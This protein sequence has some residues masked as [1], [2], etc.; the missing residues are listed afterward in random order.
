MKLGSMPE[1]LS[2]A[3]AW[4]KS[5]LITRSQNLNSS[6]MLATLQSSLCH[7]V[8]PMNRG[9]LF[10]MMFPTVVIQL[11]SIPLIYSLNYLSEY[12]TL[13]CVHLC[14]CTRPI[15]IQFN[16]LFILYNLIHKYEYSCSAIS[17]SYS[18]FAISNSYSYFIKS[19]SI[20]T[21]RIQHLSRWLIGYIAGGQYY[22]QFP[23]FFVYENCGRS[24]VNLFER[25]IHPLLNYRTVSYPLQR[26]LLLLANHKVPKCHRELFY[27]I[28]R[29]M[30][31]LN[32]IETIETTTVSLS[33]DCWPRYHFLY[34]MV[35]IT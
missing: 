4:M 5:S 26:I 21:S 16:F 12:V 35:L 34:S 24:I 17:H 15:V 7:G 32:E 3:S 1:R 11:S 30:L 25:V 14:Y 23:S 18:S 8:L 20:F 31:H 19:I 22:F 10:G 27:K 9:M 29:N 13:K 6:I 2:W 28:Q 33:K